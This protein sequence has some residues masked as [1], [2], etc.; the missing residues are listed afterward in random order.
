MPVIAPIHTFRPD[1]LRPPTPAMRLP[2][3]RSDFTAHNQAAPIVGCPSQRPSRRL[4]QTSRCVL[5]LKP[6]H[7]KSPGIPMPG[8]N[9][10]CPVPGSWF[11]LPR[12]RSI[13]LK[14]HQIAHLARRL[15][16]RL[17][18]D[19]PAPRRSENKLHHL[20]IAAVV[21]DSAAR[22]SRPAHVH[23]HARAT[24]CV[25]RAGAKSI[26]KIHPLAR[27]RVMRAERVVR[28][29]VPRRRPVE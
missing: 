21:R 27:R 2:P 25:R 10:S 11:L 23:M 29:R 3:L 16:D 19:V 7:K 1:S 24:R 15:V 8:Q 5:D 20:R 28:P 4:P 22:N 14:L 26:D 17:K 9:H 6:P 12:A 18:L 13:K